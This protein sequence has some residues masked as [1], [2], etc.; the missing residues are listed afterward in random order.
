MSGV[1]GAIL[2]ILAAFDTRASA[3]KHRIVVGTFETEFLYT[4]EY[5][6]GLR[7]LALAAR[8]AVSA[9]SSWITL[10]HDKTKLYGTDW[11]GE[12]PTFV[13]YDVTDPYDIQV[14]KTLVG[15][16]TCTGSKSIFVN[17]IQQEPYSVYGNY[18]Y[19]DARCGTVMSVYDNGTLK[20]VVQE[21]KYA[22]GS[23][24]HGTAI[25]PNGEF[26]LSADTIGNLIWTHQIDQTTGF[27]SIV[28]V[29]DGPTEGAGPRHIAIHENGNYVYIVMEEA[30]EVVQYI[31]SDNGVLSQTG[32][33]YPLL[34]TGLDPA[35]YW[36]DEVAISREN[37]Y[38][39]ATNRARNNTEK[40][41]LSAFELTS[42]GQI[43]RQLFL[44]ETT[45]SGGFANSV[46]ASPFDDALVTLTDN[47]TGFVQIWH[48]DDG[49]IAHLDIQD[50]QGCCANA[51]WLD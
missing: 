30:S 37:K 10:N 6:D 12:E 11:N 39:W 5:D 20:E 47:S 51:V 3:T 44:T 13:S 25:S 15:D 41:Y 35:D 26:L 17:A 43:T 42:A 50:G 2:L 49:L 24:V 46:A 8:S 31:V 7:A 38:L 34:P 19:G 27:L 1:F 21:Y 36:A 33:I 29:L 16:R 40:G 14:E 23:A 48:V 45:T 28:D 9:G 22:A 32:D 18:Y 4:V